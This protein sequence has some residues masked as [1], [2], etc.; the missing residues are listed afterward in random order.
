MIELHLPEPYDLQREIALHPAKRKVICAGRRAGKT[1]LAARMAVGGDKSNGFGNGLLD[2]KRVLLSSTSQ[3]QADIFW[4]YITN[5]LAPLY[6]YPAFYK[7]EVKRIIRLGK[8]QIK[9]KTGSNPDALRSDHADLMVLDECAR[10]DANAWSQVGA[11]MLADSNGD[12]VF[13]ST[14]KRRNWFFNIFNYGND[15]HNAEWQSWQFPTHANPHLDESAVTRLVEDMTEENYQQEILAEF[16]ESSGAVFRYVEG[17]CVAAP[18][19]PYHGEFVFGIDWA[20]SSDFTVVVVMDTTRNTMVD[21]DRFNGVDWTLQRG[22]IRNLYDQWK[23]HTV[24]AESNSIGSPN[25]EALCDE[26]LPMVAFETTSASKPPLIESLI[27]AF[28]RGEITCLND[29][30]IKGE[31]MAYERVVGASGRSQYS[32][33]EGMHDDC[34]IALALAWHGCINTTTYGDYQFADYRG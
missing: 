28:D 13:I 3:D 14:P 22:R 16:L 1:T 10:L 11:P 26:G 34:V 33:P 27:L 19:T 21:F 17:R 23:P 12:A 20:K 30:V 29:P 18:H 5:W 6:G 9:V 2:G 25:I 4:E 7:N 24:W 31:L 15:P 32:A 8:G